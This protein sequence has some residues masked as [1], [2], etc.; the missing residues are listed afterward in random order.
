MRAPRWGMQ[1]AIRHRP[2]M[3]RGGD[4][5]YADVGYKKQDITPDYKFSDL[6]RPLS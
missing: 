1:A 5:R 2:E 6:Q 4:F 3:L